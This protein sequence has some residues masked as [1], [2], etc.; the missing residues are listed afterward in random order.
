MCFSIPHVTLTFW[1]YNRAMAHKHASKSSSNKRGS[2]RRFASVLSGKKLGTHAP[3][4]VQAQVSEKEK[5]LRHFKKVDPVFFAATKAHHASLPDSLSRRRGAGALF[6]ALCS[7]VVSQ[8]LGR[9][10]A[11]SIYA[12]LQSLC[13]GVVTEEA[14]AG[15]SIP[16][17][18]SVGLSTAKAKT[19]QAIAE[20]TRAGELLLHTYHR[21]PETEVSERLQSIWGLGPWSVDMF[22]LF[23]L[24]RSDVFSAGDLGLIRGI[25]YIY[26]L[27]KGISKEEALTRSL[28]WSPYRT[29][30]SMLLW[31]TRDAAPAIDTKAD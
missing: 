4:K 2:V 15:L 25:E 12:R 31:R 29:Y 16:E 5:A 7:T 17:L 9:P 24:G 30:A 27:P 26:Q 10:A 11:Q 19:L 22:M 28:L 6:A 3:R 21:I 20:A 13:G 18:R 1:C 14:I 23:S 8:Q